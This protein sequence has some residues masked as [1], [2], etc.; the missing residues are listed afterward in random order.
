[1]IVHSDSG[2]GLLLAFLLMVGAVLSLLLTVVFVASRKFRLAARTLLLTLGGLI[3]WIL[4]VT[5]V[6]GLTPQTIVKIGDSYC[7]DIRCLGI[8]AV[9][10][11]AKG[12]ETVY[13]L[14]VHIFSDTDTIKVSFGKISL[15]LLDEQGRRF[16]LMQDPSATPYDSVVDPR[17]SFRTTLTFVAPSNARQLF[18]TEE[19]KKDGVQPQSDGKAP[20]WAKLIGAWF[21]LGGLGND[22]SLF[23]KPTLLRVL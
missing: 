11:E 16:P 3:L 12:S 5:A 13:N 18:L 19:D 23:H 9:R 2:L 8:D 14:D 21:Y 17:Q 22:T 15:F 20:A 4:V 7:A 10:T 6:A 1:M